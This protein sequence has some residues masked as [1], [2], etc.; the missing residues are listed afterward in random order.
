SKEFGWQMC[1]VPTREL[2][3][4]GIN[5]LAYPE[6]RLKRNQG[7]HHYHYGVAQKQ[8]DERKRQMRKHRKFSL[9]MRKKS[10]HS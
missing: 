10:S 9:E 1:H 8:C 5:S 2:D 4:D 7:R 6:L 3:K